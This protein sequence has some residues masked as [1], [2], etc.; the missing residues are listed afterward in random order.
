[1]GEEITQINFTDNIALED[2]DTLEL[3]SQ[4]DEVNPTL[5]RYDEKIKMQYM[6][7]IYKNHLCIQH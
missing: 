2:I 3:V 5:H 1:M 6:K 4:I 7:L